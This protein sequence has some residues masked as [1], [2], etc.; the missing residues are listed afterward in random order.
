[1]HAQAKD[2]Q[3]GVFMKK[4]VEAV[5]TRSL[6]VL[7]S[8]A[9]SLMLS[10][11]VRILA[12]GPD[13]SENEWTYEEEYWHMKAAGYGEFP[14]NF[15]STSREFKDFPS[16]FPG[17]TTPSE[18]KIVGWKKMP[19]GTYYYD[20]S[21]KM[22]IGWHKI[23]N[24]WYYF[25]KNG[26]MQTGWQKVD[27]QDYYLGTDGKM[28]TG[29]KE[30]KGEWY[31]FS[32]D[33]AMRRDWQHINGKWYYFDSQGV[34]QTG[35]KK[36]AGKWYY[37][38]SSGESAEHEWLSLNGKWYYFTPNCELGVNMWVLG[39]ENVEYYAGPDGAW[40]GQTRK[41]IS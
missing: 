30:V 23:D 9:V 39:P 14:E 10:H 25:N 35:W 3:K 12:Y 41:K 32:S 18:N 26:T 40:T 24:W 7:I 6:V 21:G 15:P 31:Y 17:T 16:T 36:L 22:L 4:K 11:K 13:E 28:A 29:W 1:M 27:N 34:M 2:G 38:K 5:V 20:S 19:N 8:M 37:F 33:G